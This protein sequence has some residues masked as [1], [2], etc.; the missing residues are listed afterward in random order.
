MSRFWRCGRVVGRKNE[1][2]AG[3]G[4]IGAME[5]NTG[6]DVRKKMRYIVSKSG[7]GK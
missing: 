6:K 3:D 1:E 7:K 5:C 4:D 2:A